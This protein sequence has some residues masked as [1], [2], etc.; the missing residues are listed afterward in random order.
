MAI[1]KDEL[2]QIIQKSFPE[3]VIEIIDLVGD[4][5]HY[6]VKITD[7]SFTG[8]GRIEQHRMVNLALNKELRS[9]ILHAMQLKTSSY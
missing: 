3:G 2:H 4:N 8:K 5:N 1:A 9:E 7:K 6:S